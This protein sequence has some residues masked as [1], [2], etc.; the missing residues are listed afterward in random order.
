MVDHFWVENRLTFA[1]V[2]SAVVRRLDAKQKPSS[3]FHWLPTL[4]M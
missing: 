4:E 1:T 3:C 2:G